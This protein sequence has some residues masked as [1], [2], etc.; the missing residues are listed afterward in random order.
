[1]APDQTRIEAVVNWP[2]HDSL[3]QFRGVLGLTG[4]CR[5]FI[6]KHASIAYRLIKILEKNAFCWHDKAPQ[7]FDTLKQL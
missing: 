1:M 7:A 3:K 5:C 2:I 4:F 6:N